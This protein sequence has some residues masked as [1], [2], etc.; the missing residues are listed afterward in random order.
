MFRDP[1]ALPYPTMTQPLLLDQRFNR[2]SALRVI[3]NPWQLRAVNLGWTIVEQ[4][5]Q[6]LR[7]TM[8][9]SIVTHTILTDPYYK[10]TGFRV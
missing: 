7:C 10:W 6:G 8:E 4:D 5:S 1:L 3:G 2:T 9:T